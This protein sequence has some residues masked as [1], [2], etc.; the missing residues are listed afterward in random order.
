MHHHDA[1]ARVDDG[2]RL[3][4]VLQRVIEHKYL[5]VF[6]AFVTEYDTVRVV[7]FEKKLAKLP[8]WFKG[9][10]SFTTCIAACT[11]HERATRFMTHV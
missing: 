8:Q 6:P 11:S 5:A 10:L 7:G 9:R 3:Y 4:A 2:V 1:T